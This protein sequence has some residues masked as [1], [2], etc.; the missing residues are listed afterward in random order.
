F[1]TGGYF[2]TKEGKVKINFITIE[3]DAARQ[4]EKDEKKIVYRLDRLG[5][6]LLELVT[7]PDIK[8]PEQ[9]KDA[10]RAIGEV[11]RLTCKAKRGQGTARQDI[12]VSIKD[13]ARCEIKG[14][15]EFDLIDE[16]VRKEV[17]RQVMLI[18]IKK[19]LAKRKITLSKEVKNHYDVTSVFRNT[20]SKIIKPVLKKKG[21]VYA[22]KLPGFACLIGGAKG[23][24]RLGQ[25]FSSHAKIHAGVK[26]IFHSDELP[27]YGVTKE[28]VEKITKQ[29]NCKKE[30]AFILVTEKRE[31]ALTAIEAVYKRAL[32]CFHGVPGETRNPQEDGT[33][34]YMRPLGS[35][36]RM[37]PETDIKVRKITEKMIT[38]TTLPETADKRYAKYVKHG[39]SKEQANKMKLSNWACYFNKTITTGKV[40]A[41]LAATVLLNT[42]TSLKRDGFPVE[43]LQKERITEVLLAVQKGKV[44]K[45]VITEILGQLSENPHA[46]LND[47]IKTLGF[48]SK[49]T[50]EVETM[51]KKVVA[52]NKAM[53]KEQGMRALGPLM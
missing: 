34:E 35:G 4:I 22:L 33:S 24:P 6:P 52:A 37:Y 14:A 29:L 51:V 10:A 32:K 45:D 31:T 28:N 20:E 11:C 16:Y 38:E 18:K 36:A 1:S 27:N 13:G 2:Q 44:S 46:D 43:K 25:E 50:K 40:D 21:V 12:N 5:I 53:I 49:D 7:A 3:E 19:E 8:T 48:E 47:L 41:K 26:G 42:L 9:A 30:D 39:L 23:K 15:S 17:E